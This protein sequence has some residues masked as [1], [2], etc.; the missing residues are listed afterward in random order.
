MREAVSNIV[1]MITGS[2]I[3][4][5]GLIYLIFQYN[6]ISSLTENIIKNVTED[7]KF[8]QQYNTVDINTVSEEEIYAAIMGYREYPIM[9]NG[10]LIPPDGQDYNVYFSNIKKGLYNKEYRYDDNRN[11]TMIIYS[12]KGS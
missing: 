3:I 8:F 10:S 2:V 9:V 5:L 6:T 4:S 12:L 11:I 7:K 1:E